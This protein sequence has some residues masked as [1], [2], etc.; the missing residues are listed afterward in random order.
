MKKYKNIFNKY[1]KIGY[2]ERDFV[3]AFSRLTQVFILL[4][5]PTTYLY[6]TNDD[7][8][9][10]ITEDTSHIS[11]SFINNSTNSYT[12]TKFNPYIVPLDADLYDTVYSKNIRKFKNIDVQKQIIAASHRSD[13]DAEYLLL[14]A[15]I[16]S[17]LNPKAKARTSTATGIFQFLEQ[18]WLEVIRDYGAKY[19]LEK[20][21]KMIRKGKKG[22]PH[23]LYVKNKK[24]ERRILN[25]RFDP[26][27]ST[28]MAIEFT[29]KN[30]EFLEKELKVKA[31]N[32]NLYTVHFF[33]KNNAKKFFK[34]LHKKPHWNPIDFFGRGVVNRNKGVFYFKN[35]KT[36]RSFGQIHS[37]FEKRINK[38]RNMVNLS[39][40]DNKNYP[41]RRP[42][43]KGP[44][45]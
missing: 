3:D 35:G 26:T 25:M 32:V 12:S 16:E 38:A 40:L 43:K 41:P 10:N 34:I 45:A 9:N 30:K 33:G 44:K 4:A 19:G 21:A 39:L 14:L 24:E 13:I 36:P 8:H 28:Q 37:E 6:Y 20:E 31:T 27:I 7:Y 18:T 15:T 23:L 42:T 1:A 2:V 22:N 29:N 17:S 5:A 11:S